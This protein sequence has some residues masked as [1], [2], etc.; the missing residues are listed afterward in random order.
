MHKICDWCDAHASYIDVRYNS[1]CACT[2]HR[3]ELVRIV[4]LAVKR[5]GQ[6][7]C[8]DIAEHAVSQIKNERA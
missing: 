6:S 4:E 5:T 2:R 7:F 1:G 3:R 8:G